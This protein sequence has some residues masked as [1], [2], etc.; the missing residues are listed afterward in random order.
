[1]DMSVAPSFCPIVGTRSEVV[2]ILLLLGLDPG[3][4]KQVGILCGQE[5]TRRIGDYK[6][7]YGYTDI[8]LLRWGRPA[9]PVWT[10]RVALGAEGVG[11]GSRPE[12]WESGLVELGWQGVKPRAAT[13]P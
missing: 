2:V 11:V 3:K 13:L 12:D 8:D 7:K 9:A 10:E 5:S 1:M 4:I 6:V